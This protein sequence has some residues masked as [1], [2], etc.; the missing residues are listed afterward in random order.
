[1]STG[2]AHPPATR[3][4]PMSRLVDI[5]VSEDDVV[6]NESLAR[7][8]ESASL[9]DLGEH[10]S[11]LDAFWRQTDNLYHRVRALFFLS[12]IHRFQLAQHLSNEQPGLIPFD[13]YE[14]MLDRRFI[15]TIDSLLKVQEQQGMSD[16]V[17]SALAH[18][19]R[20]LAFQ[21]LADQ[22]RK[23]VRTVRGN[24]WMFRTGH[25]T[26]HPLRIRKELVEVDP[27][28][29]VRPTIVEKTSVRM[30]FSHSGWSD[31]FFLGMDY[32]SGAQVINAAVNLGVR[33]RDPEPRPP[34]ECYFRIIDEP[35][36]RLVSVD[37]KA[38]TDVT[39]ISE[40]FDFARDYLGLLKAAVIASGIVPPGMEGCE[41]GHR[42]PALSPRRPGKRDRTGQ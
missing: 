22:V 21:T 23:S 31:I 41:T 36:L 25:P 29:G 8:C 27:T 38:A 10:L 42:R 18:A 11:A 7:V 34:I 14:H 35:V 2:S 40:V 15:E 30:D 3:T 6:R 37:L 13:S 32:P 12:D 5:I 16:G 20:D 1:M 24:Q 19:Y 26:D 17:S 28:V 4:L 39:T 33:G 9:T